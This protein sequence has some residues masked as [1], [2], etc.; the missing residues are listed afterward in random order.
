M[1]AMICSQVQDFY[2]YLKF[3]RGDQ[4][5]LALY[6]LF[7][8]CSMLYNVKVPG[9]GSPHHYPKIQLSYLLILQYWKTINFCARDMMKDNMA[10][11]NEELGEIGFSILSRAVLG[12]HTTD[13]FDHMNKIYSM[14]SMYRDIKN[15]VFRDNAVPTSLSWRHQINRTGEEVLTVGLHFKRLIRQIK[16]ETFRSYSPHIQHSRNSVT[17]NVHLTTNICQ[18]VWMPY[19]KLVTYIQDLTKCISTDIHGYFLYSFHDLWPD[20]KSG[21]DQ[22]DYHIEF[23]E[24]VDNEDHQHDN[25]QNLEAGFDESLDQ[26]DALS[27]IQCFDESE[28][29]ESVDLDRSWNAWG[30]IHNENRVVGPRNRKPVNR[31]LPSKRRVVFIPIE[32]LSSDDD[33]NPH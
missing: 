30:T 1:I 31:Y 7:I 8:A 32:Q 19:D 27:P 9:R 33:K 14:I 13:E 28:H 17:A 11:F 22:N 29:D 23:D 2:V 15:E 25:D 12:D 24:S 18:P 20:A 6:R 26:L 10:I 16:S 21:I 4:C 5:I 3:N